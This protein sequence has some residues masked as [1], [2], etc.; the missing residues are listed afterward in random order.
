M[1]SF[2][3]F[4]VFAVLLINTQFIAAKSS[5]LCPGVNGKPNQTHGYCT[6]SI[7]DDERK[8]N[9]IGK[10]FTMWKEEIKQVDGKFTCDKLDLNGSDATESF[11]C[12]VAGKLALPDTTSNNRLKKVN[13][14]CGQTT[15][16]K[17]LK[18]NHYLPPGTCLR[19]RPF[20][21][22]KCVTCKFLVHS[23]KLKK[24]LN[25]CI[26][27]QKLISMILYLIS[28]IK[29]NNHYLLTSFH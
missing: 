8:A 18:D 9:K 19:I 22:A 17:H 4:I 29:S 16:P 24:S 1:Q 5:F 21:L 23:T 11:C 13:K 2:N 12:D 6:R 20:P 15:A 28:P 25:D 10:E 7:K 3:L 26:R 27:E 14:L